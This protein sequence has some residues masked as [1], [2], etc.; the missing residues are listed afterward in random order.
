MNNQIDAVK[1]IKDGYGEKPITQFDKLKSLDKKAK[2]PAKV[3]AYVFGTVATLVLGTGMCL[4]MKVIGDLMAVGIVIGVVGI[5]MASV[6]YPI[7]KAIMKSRKAKYC[8]RIFELSEEILA[9]EE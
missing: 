7:Y 3:F 5:I 1:K 2:R 4:A 9:T 6:N 8:R